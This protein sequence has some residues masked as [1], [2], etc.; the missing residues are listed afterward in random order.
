MPHQP[1]KESKG[2]SEKRSANTQDLRTSDS[3]IS[4]QFGNINSRFTAKGNPKKNIKEAY[5]RSRA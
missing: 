4:S 2:F 3:K 5:S 1:K